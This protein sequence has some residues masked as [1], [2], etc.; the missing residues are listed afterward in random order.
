MAENGQALTGHNPGAL[1]G[2]I[3][4]ESS[5]KKRGRFERRKTSRNFQRVSCRRLD[6]FGVAT[7]QR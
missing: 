6:K 2:A 1:Q 4:C 5:T 7:R 3:N